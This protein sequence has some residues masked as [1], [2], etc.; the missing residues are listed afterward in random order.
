M[1]LLF[2]LALAFATMGS[3]MFLVWLISRLINNAGI[4]D[5]AWAAGFSILLLLYLL[6][7][8]NFGARQIFLAILVSVWSLRLFL[9]LSLRFLKSYPTEDPRYSELRTAFGAHPDAKMLLVFLWQGFVL[10]LMSAPIAA[11]MADSAAEISVIH[12]LASLLCLMSI[13]GEA[14]ADFQLSSFASEPANKGLSCQSGLWQYSRHPNY[15]F[16][17][18]VSVSFSIFALASPYGIWTLFCPLLLLHLLLNV[19][20]VKPAEE[21]SLKTRS[22]YSEYQKRTSA[23]IPWFRRVS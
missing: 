13:T 17:W 8:R 22:D 21:H 20:G 19:T 23:F 16:E 11:V 12:C 15:F 1:S 14:L 3:I 10:V 2:L 9:H 7:C 5:L 4:V 6:I 18:M